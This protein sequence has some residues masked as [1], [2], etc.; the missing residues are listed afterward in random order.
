MFTIIIETN[1]AINSNEVNT[2]EKD[3]PIIIEA[4]T[5]IGKTNKAT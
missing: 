3:L 5:I 2:I 4:I 1:I